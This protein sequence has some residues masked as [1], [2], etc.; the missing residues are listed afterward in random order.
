LPPEVLDS[1]KQ[2]SK[3]MPTTKVFRDENSQATRVPSHDP[4]KLFKKSLRDF[5]DDYFVDGRNQPEMRNGSKNSDDDWSRLLP[6]VY[7]SR[8][9]GAKYLLFQTDV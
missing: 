7:C 2:E 4:W 3:Q 6:V 1:S 8:I 5:S 9:G